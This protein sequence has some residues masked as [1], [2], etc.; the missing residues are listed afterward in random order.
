MEDMPAPE[1]SPDDH[2]ILVNFACTGERI[3]QLLKQILVKLE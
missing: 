1:Y 3:E 2:T